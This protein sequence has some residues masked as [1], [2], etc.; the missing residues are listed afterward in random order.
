MSERGEDPGRYVYSALPDRPKLTWPDGKRIALWLVDNHEYY[1]I[2]PPK[3]VALPFPKTQRGHPDALGFGWKDYGNRVGIW[4]V[5][6]MLD[7]HGLKGSI[8]LNV[9]LSTTIRRRRRRVRSAAGSS[10]RTAFTTRG[11]CTSCRR[12]TSGG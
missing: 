4:R 1:E 12:R 10:S 9:A 7:R 5:I 2:L 3:P 6:E 11:T 8:C